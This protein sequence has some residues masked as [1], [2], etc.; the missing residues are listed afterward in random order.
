MHF[1]V[2]RAVFGP[3]D[4]KKHDRVITVPIQLA[5]TN[6]LVVTLGSKPNAAIRILVDTPK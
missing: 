2:E 5:A 4:F 1:G 6:D 3:D